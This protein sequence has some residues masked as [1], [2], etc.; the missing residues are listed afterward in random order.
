VT[1]NPL[2]LEDVDDPHDW[3]RIS[4]AMER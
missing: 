4:A 3:K 2:V 1:E